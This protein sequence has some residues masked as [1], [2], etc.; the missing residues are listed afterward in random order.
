MAKMIDE[1][2][3]QDLKDRIIELQKQID[4]YRN[5]FESCSVGYDEKRDA[6]YCKACGAWHDAMC[7]DEGCDYCKGRAKDAVDD[8]KQ[9]IMMDIEEFKKGKEIQLIEGMWIGRPVIMKVMDEFKKELE[10]GK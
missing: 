7:K 5:I 4:K 9:R 6:F 2:K 1:L 10:G 3:M 8:M